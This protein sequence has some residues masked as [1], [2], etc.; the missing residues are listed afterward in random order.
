MCFEKVVAGL[1]H[2][3]KY[4]LGTEL[5]MASM[6]G[7]EQ[8]IATLGAQLFAEVADAGLKG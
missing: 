6:E 3:L 7:V 4:I 2:Y 1:F 5:R 8:A